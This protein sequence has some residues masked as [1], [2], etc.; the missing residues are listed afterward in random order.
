MFL[1]KSTP[2]KNFKRRTYF[3]R[4]VKLFKKTSNYN[5]CTKKTIKINL[6]F[7]FF[8]KKTFKKLF[9][10]NKIISFLYFFPNKWLSK[11]IKNSSP[12]SRQNKSYA[13][14]ID[15]RQINSCN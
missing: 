8:F 10:K 1:Q 5:V 2:F 11:K 13:S 14:K 12:L 15:Q 9:R 4:Q 6:K 3:F 7:F